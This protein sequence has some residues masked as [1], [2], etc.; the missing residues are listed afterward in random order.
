MPRVTFMPDS[1]TIDVAQGENLLRAAM[2]ADVRITA[3]CGGDGTCGKCRI[4]VEHGVVDFVPTHL[5]TDAQ[6]SDG[7]VLAC[8]SHVTGDV[9]VRVPPESRPGTAP[10]R[11]HSRRI[12]NPVL[13]ADAHA[14]RLPDKRSSLV[15]AK[16]HVKVAEPDHTNNQSDLSR[17]LQGLRRE[18]HLKGAQVT[19]DAARELPALLR[20]GDWS[21]T[22]IV[23]EPLTGPPLVTGFQAGDTT[24]RQYAAAVDIGTTTVEIAIIDLVSRETV[25]QATEY[26]AQVDRGEDVIA[27]IIGSTR[28]EGLHELQRLVIGTISKL[29]TRLLDEADVSVDDLIVYVA[30]GNTVMT[31]LLLGMSPENIRSA[32]YVPAASFFPWTEAAVI[33]LPASPATRLITIPCPASWMGGDIVAGV[34]AAGIPWSEKMTL[35]VDIGT[36]GEIVLGNK[37]FLVSCSC[38][39]GPAFEGGGIDHGMRAAEGA[40]EQVRIDPDTLEATL[41]T[42][43]SVKPLGICG[44]G[45]I[46][47]VSEL[48]LAGAIDRSGKFAED[49][50]SSRIRRSER[51]TEYVLVPAEDSGIGADIV[52]GE[53]DIE[54][55]MRAKAAIFAGITLLLESLDLTLDAIEEVIVAGGFGH[56][57]D[58]ERVTVLGML[59]ELPPERF[60]FIGNS[61]LLGA[62]L[63]ASSRKMLESSSKVAEAMTYL[64]LSVNAGFMEMYISS[65]FL[66]HTD[67]ALFPQTEALLAEQLSAKAVK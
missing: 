7:Y 19:L 23:T 66:P 18:Q 37:D 53:T 47:T 41:L 3:S 67:L 60:A 57:L 26:N 44:S 64:E 21:V 32:P 20:E 49:T 61:S 52:L 1:V 34:V 43:G 39:A 24:L 29:A 17:V 9:V 58:L 13:S 36:N 51:G 42:I 56:Y 63:V 33:G 50:G 55:L 12:P 59:P 30:A 2:M 46:D 8:T 14:A 16:H 45:L 38:S 11:G 65:L 10:T 31:H 48:F 54:N 27:R 5:L 40:V 35:F 25:A 6:V 62:R 4:V 22:A 15:V 28:P